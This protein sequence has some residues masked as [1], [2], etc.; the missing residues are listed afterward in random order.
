MSKQL[1]F[2]TI[3]VLLFLAGW[4]ISSRINVSFWSPN[5]QYLAFVSYQIVPRME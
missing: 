2:L 5:S 4:P 1:W 3:G